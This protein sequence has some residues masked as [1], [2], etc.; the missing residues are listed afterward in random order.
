MVFHQNGV[1]GN[2]VYSSYCPPSRNTDDKVDTMNSDARQKIV[3]ALNLLGEANPQ[4]TD[5]KWLE[6]LTVRIASDIREWDI[7]ECWPWDEWPGREERFPNTTRQDVGIDAVAVRRDGNQFIAIQCKA[8]QLDER[9]NGSSID[10]SEIDKFGSA[11]ANHFWAER[12]LVTNGSV[13][14][15]DNV[16]SVEGMVD[17]PIKLINITADLK[18]EQ[19]ASF[20]EPPCPHCANPGDET[21]RRTK[22][23]MQNEAVAESVRILREHEETDSGGSPVGQARGKIILPCGTGKTRISLRIVEELTPHGGL[24]IVLCPSIALVAQIRREY[25]QNASRSIRALAVC[26]DTTAGYD[27]KKEDSRNLTSDPTAD[28]SHVG[29][30]FVKGMVTTD[31]AEIAQWISDGRDDAERISVIFGTYQSGARV[32]EALK[33]TG[34]TASV[35][36]CDEAHRTAGLRRKKSPARNATGQEQRIR[37]FTLC[38]DNEAMPATYRV[39][40]TA[41]PRIYNPAA[42]TK[43]TK[44]TGGEWHV[45]SMDDEEVFGVELYRKS[46][47]EAVENR[48][49][50]DYR[51]IAVGISEGDAYAVANALAA[52]T[53]SASGRNALTTTDFL[54]GLAFALAMGGAT[55][56]QGDASVSIKSCIAF[57]NTVNKSKHMA[58]ELA[59]QPVY[60]WVQTR[61]D[62]AGSKSG[63]VRFSLQ[64]LDATSNVTQ[65]DGAK[66]N[67]AAATTE[68]PHGIVNVGIFGEGTDSPS[69]SA[70]AFLEPRKSP[71][72]VIQAVGRAMR[73]APDKDVGY[74][75]CP[76][77]IPQH[78]DPE[79]WLSVSNMDEGWQELGQ[80]LLALRAHDSRIEEEL[81]DLMTLYIP[82]PPEVVTTFIGVVPPGKQRIQYVAHIGAPGEAQRDLERVLTGKSSVEQVFSHLEV[83]E[84]PLPVGLPNGL[85]L[86]YGDD[87]DGRPTL[88]MGDADSGESIPPHGLVDGQGQTYGDGLSKTPPQPTTIITGKQNAD[89]TMEIRMDT[90]PRQKP[91][92]DGT[93][94]GITI[95]VVKRTTKDM[96][97]KGTGVKQQTGEELEGERRARAER[98]AQQMLD[99]R[100]MQEYGNAI[101]MNLL[102]KS[103]LTDN[104]VARD[105]NILA[106]VISEAAYQLKSDELQPNLDAQFGLDNLDTDKRNKQADGCTIAALL[107]MNAAMLHQRIAN[108][109]WISGISNL[110]AVKSDT[111]VVGRMRQEWERIM[112]HDFRPVLEPAVETIYAVEGTRKLA[113]LERALRHIAASAE[114][115]AEA[116]ADMG[117]DHAGPLFNKVMGNQASDGAFFTRPPAASLAA[118]LTLDAIG[119]DVDW[120]DPDVWRH[121]KTVDLACGSGTLLAAM[122]TD[123]KRRAEERGAT[124]HDLAAL[125]K[126][127]VEDTLVGLDINPVSLQLAAAQLTAGNQEIRYRKMGL[128]Q[129]PYG[130]QKNNPTRVAAGTLELIGQSAIVARPGQ[131]DIEDDAIG[132]KAVWQTDSRQADPELED[133][134]EAVRDARIVI[135]NPPFTERVRMGEKFPKP[136]QESL[137]KRVDALEDML[138]NADSELDDVVSRRA[139]APLFVTLA[140]QI[141]KKDFGVLAMLNPTI[142]F[143]STS[144]DKERRFLASRF[145]VHTVLTCHEP[146]NA[147]LSTNTNIN[148]SIVVLGRAY[149]A[150]PKTTRFIN[151]DRFPADETEVADFHDCLSRVTVGAIPNGWGEVSEW[152]AEQMEAGNWTPAVWRTSELAKEAA[153]YASPD[154]GL[155]S[156]SDLEGMSMNLTRPNLV[157][158]FE[159]PHTETSGSFPIL[160]SRGADAQTHIES[161]PDEYRLPK[162]RNEAIRVG[163]GGTYPESDK[164]LAKASFLLVTDGQASNTARLTAV[165]SDEKLVG[166][167][168]MPVTG[169]SLDEAKAFAVFLNSTA[170]RLQIMSNAGRKITFPMYSPASYSGIRVPNVKGDTRVRD[171]LADCWERTKDMEVPQYRD[172]ECEV[173]QLWDEAVA[174]AMGWD[175]DELTRLRLLLHDEPHV[176]G[177]GHG[178]YADEINDDLDEDGDD[179][180]METDEDQE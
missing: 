58:A 121:H 32:A 95:N 140:D 35:L 56:H 27:P 97:N 12:W 70:V 106:D 155:L 136:V 167:S 171:I 148:E 114:R 109:G 129:M 176:R 78:A 61:L 166:V 113:G 94:G 16:S 11:T 40:Q 82:K 147:N 6:E 74:I 162:K 122:M 157:L 46:Y 158:N 134:V 130:P 65:R 161:A 29:M 152:P 175:A 180:A 10:K 26:S 154:S 144:A 156:I 131:M 38:H 37:D 123:M 159:A 68:A 33:E 30:G 143:S 23:C 124:K 21:Q 107:M 28:T 36:I 165:A 34:A 150:R 160:K 112:R 43:V 53:Q 14:W 2:G 127:A 17:N 145:H 153:W 138:V 18:Q 25:L 163:N 90:V 92:K 170:G 126:I 62:Q 173:R 77:L 117:A 69:L 115:I 71:I 80:I 86:T 164:M 135:M 172:G 87:R 177:L 85:A 116:Y 104:R 41:T 13:P 119:D 66:G 125:Q 110:A 174:E 42:A 89:G 1:R 76:I 54:R 108:G 9:G 133:A 96:I 169:V 19:G 51:I 91:H 20:A 128:H 3:E 44:D 75:I 118:R 149:E 93:P 99:L 168:W 79:T 151:L 5:G 142:L 67:L 52:D 72:D 57:M 98:N 50:A 102:A 47:K 24:S 64:H 81:S 4:T 179:S 139:V 146:G 105:L 60:N 59:S 31:A 83:L 141:V 45:R 132:S 100:E 111:N 120:S 8:R 7:D 84:S 63:G 73:T 22:S 55:E 49:L 137:R 48:W 15:S 178:Q 39:Y 101:T 103:G 88:V